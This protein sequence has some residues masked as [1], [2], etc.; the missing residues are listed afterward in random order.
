M[1]ADRCVV[2]AVPAGQN[3]P[4]HRQRLRATVRAV[5]GQVQPV[6]DQNAKV[7]PLPRH[8]RG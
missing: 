8:R 7:D 3:R 5:L 6:F 1:T 2:D 4:N